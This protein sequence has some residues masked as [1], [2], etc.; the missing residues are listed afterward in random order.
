MKSNEEIRTL[1]VHTGGGWGGGENQALSLLAGLNDRGCKASLIARHDGALA[2]RAE[3]KGLSVV[4][5]VIPPK[6][7]ACFLVGSQA[8]IAVSR[9][10]PQLIHAHD[11]DGLAIARALARPHRLPVVLSR[12]VASPLRRNLLSRFK[13]APS[14][15]AGVVAISRTVKDVMIRS[16]FPSE[17][18]YIAPSGLDIGALDATSPDSKLRDRYAGSHLVG[19]IGSLTAKKNW[20]ML[21]RVAAEP[22][23]GNLNIQWVIAGAGPTQ[24][25]LKRLAHKLGVS[26]R[27]HFLGFRPDAPAVLKALDVLFFPSLIEGASVT[28][29]E[30]MVCGVPVVAVNCPGTAESLSGSGRLVEAGDIA[31]AAK[32]ITGILQD[33]EEYAATADAQREIAVTRYSIATT[34]DKTLEAYRAILSNRQ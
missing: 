18:I 2:L 21:I 25:E 3:E 8:S 9:T 34:L 4:P 20:E 13:Y 22:P 6:P 26:D 17:R 7:L 19:G 23:C 10:K 12:R 30:A 29:R 1:H 16:G 32:A 33:K 15:I 11:S 27:I 5:M 24:G 31:G 14:R 28:V